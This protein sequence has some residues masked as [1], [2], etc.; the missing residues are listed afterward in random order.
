MKKEEKERKKN[1]RVGEDACLPRVHYL[2]LARGARGEG[3][4]R[5][6]NTRFI[7]RVE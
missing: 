5:L 1:R 7:R 6:L 3:A 2:G 4:Y